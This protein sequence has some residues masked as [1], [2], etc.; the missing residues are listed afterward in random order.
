MLLSGSE[1]FAFV[2][3]TVA[4]MAT[5]GVTV[6]SL[7]GTALS[8]GAAAGFAMEAG[9]VAARLSMIVFLAFGL[10]IVSGVMDVLFDWVKLAG[11]A[12]LIWI[13][14]KTIRHPPGLTAQ[15]DGSG[16]GAGAQVMRGFIVLW[17]NPKALIFFGAFVPQFIDPAS[18]VGLQVMFLGAIW[19]LTAL[20]TDSGY[21]LLAGGAR[22]MFR[23]RAAKR[24]GW[25]S[26][27][28]LIG[29]GV[30]LALQRKA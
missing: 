27:S 18:G 10:D 24:L 20:M 23:G 8:H 22:R 15:A 3:A 11:A 25:V 12:Y 16:P 28:I 14:I 7:T 30:W 26:G 6:S 13:G 9:A 17:S 4:V 2:L 5:P 29:A 19:V 21:I 1:L